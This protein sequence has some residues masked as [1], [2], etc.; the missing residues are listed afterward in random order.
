MRR[1]LRQILALRHILASAGLI[2]ALGGCHHED[3]AVGHG[4][5]SG[6]ILPG[7]I[8]DA[9]L[10]YDSVKSKAPVAPPQV[11]TPADNTPGD[12]AADNAETNA[13]AAAS[14]TP[15]AVAPPVA[16]GSAASN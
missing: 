9:M 13:T 4:T 7:S 14:A 10:P 5:V 6:E 2:A 12:S 3:K 1:P 11:V 15:E 16:A 8:S